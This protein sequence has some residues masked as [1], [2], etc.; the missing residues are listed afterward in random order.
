MT[1]TVLV[2]LITAISLFWIGGVLI[3]FF[4]KQGQQAHVVSS[5]L[6]TT[7]K[8][9]EQTARMVYLAQK[10]IS[11]L[12]ITSQMTFFISDLERKL[13]RAAVSSKLFE[14][15]LSLRE[16]E[17][18][19]TDSEFVRT[20]YDLFD[21][22]PTLKADLYDFVQQYERVIQLIKTHDPN[23]LF[24]SYFDSSPLSGIYD[25]LSEMMDGLYVPEVRELFKE[26][27]KKQASKSARREFDDAAADSEDD[28]DGTGINLPPI[29]W[30]KAKKEPIGKYKK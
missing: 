8:N 25:V 7:G 27:P 6:K 22:H 1:A 10:E 3:Y 15:P 13:L 24:S 18:A 14:E 9:I 2:C 5:F 20:L 30:K 12:A 21:T 19:L 11:A 28:D 4:R 16:F 23:R 29:D 17:R 26:R